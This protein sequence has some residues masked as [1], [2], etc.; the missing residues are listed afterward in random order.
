[1]TAE[2]Q[3]R[4]LQGIKRAK[5]AGKYKSRTIDAC[6]HARI[7]LR[8]DVGTSIRNAASREVGISA[9]PGGNV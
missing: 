9:Y 6:L 3:L 4:R 1:M 5:A 7:K 8:K 2:E